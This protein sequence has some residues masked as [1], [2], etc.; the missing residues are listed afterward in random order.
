MYIFE[1]VDLVTFSNQ[2]LFEVKMAKSENGE[3][4]PVS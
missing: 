2:M 4:L 1:Q 3:R